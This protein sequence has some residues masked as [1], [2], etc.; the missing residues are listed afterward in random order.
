VAFFHVYLPTPAK[1]RNCFHGVQPSNLP[2]VVWMTVR[3]S[4][5]F[6]LTHPHPPKKASSSKARPCLSYHIHSFHNRKWAFPNANPR[7]RRTKGGRRPLVPRRERPH[8]HGLRLAIRPRFPLLRSAE[9]TPLPRSPA[10]LPWAWVRSRFAC[11]P[12][13]QTLPYFC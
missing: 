2:L 13:A 6:T 9:V 8:A 1:T 11:S 7:L 12:P 3:H 10:Q 4:H 5:R